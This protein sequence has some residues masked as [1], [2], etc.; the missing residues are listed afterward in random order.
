MRLG[1]IAVCDL[2]DDGTRLAVVSLA[3]LDPPGYLITHNP[4]FEMVDQIARIL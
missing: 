1:G 2:Q 4:R 3:Q